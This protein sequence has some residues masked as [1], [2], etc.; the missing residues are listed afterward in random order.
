MK[1]TEREGVSVVQNIVYRELKWVFREQTVD[2]YGIDAQIEVTNHEYPTGKMIAVQIKSGASYFIRTTEDGIIFR[3]DEKHK[4]YWLGHILPVIVLLY[5]PVSQECIWEVIDK[6]T[7]EQVSNTRY[8]MVIPK[9]NKFGVC[10]KAKLL[11]LAYSQNIEELAEEIDDLDVD[12]ES[13]FTMLDD[14]QKKIFLKARIK[15]DKKNASSDRIPFKDKRE[16]LADFAGEI[17]WSDIENDIVIGEQFKKLACRIENFIYRQQENTLI[18]L[19]EAGS[20]KTTLVKTVM[21]SKVKT[22]FLLIRM[23]RYCRDVL[24]DIRNE[25][26]IGNSVKVVIIDGWDALITE[27][28]LKTWHQIVDWQDN[29]GMKVIITSRYMENSIWS[30]IEILKI[31]PL[32]LDEAFYFLEVMTKRNVTK[33]ETTIGLVNIFSTPLLLKLLVVAT[34]QLGIPIEE[35][36]RENLILSFI[37]QYSE[38]ES[39]V[40]ESIAFEMMQKNEMIIMPSDSIYLKYLSRYKELSVDEGQVSFRHNSY[41]E[42]FAARYIFRQIFKDIKEPEK[43]GIA[44]RDMFANNLCSINILNYVKFFI[45]HQLNSNVA[46]EQLNYNFNYMLECGM[47]LNF[48]RGTD[49][50]K[51]ISNIFYV[52]WHITSYVNRIMHGVFRPKFSKCG[53]TNFACLINVFNKIYFSEVYL[54][55]SY[56]DFSNIKLWRC[57]LANMNF[58]NSRL[59]HANFLG[60]RLDGSD[61]QKADLSNSI[62]IGADLRYANLKDAILTG[63]NVAQCMI[64]ENSLKYFQPYKN[65]LRHIEKLIVF[66]E[67]GTI[68]YLVD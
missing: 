24:D 9:K 62:L 7:V 25:Y 1:N 6:S 61:F 18:I 19:G 8:K 67:D 30:N 46:L 54:D 65:T 56:T 37:L 52:M 55:F 68:K 63:T 34:S 60:S 53:E 64:S 23:P 51:A 57:N 15:V 42:I 5:H 29:H 10:T 2:D 47:L 17:K 58:K 50:F 38:E 28:R 11:I 36:T 14:G 26:K 49:V 13:V 59:Y 4:K 40:L 21:K 35:A 33:N 12:T 31:R 66:M 45:K 16:E 20:G 39:W 32:S 48:Q 44:M 3:F 27:E 41:Y 43:F 22:D